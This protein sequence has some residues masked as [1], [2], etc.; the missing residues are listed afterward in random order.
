M[1][2]QYGT[3]SL[4]GSRTLNVNKIS[5]NLVDLRDQFFSNTAYGQVGIG[6]IF[7]G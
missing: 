5:K 2:G 4:H 6:D 7:I 3:A 1:G